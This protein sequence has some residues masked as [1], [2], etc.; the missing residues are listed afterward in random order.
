M[1]LILH[2]ID[3]KINVDISY[4]FKST[5][6]TL[7]EKDIWLWYDGKSGKWWYMKKDN[8]IDGD[9]LLDG[10]SL[11]YLIHFLLYLLIYF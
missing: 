1:K 5:F 2:R 10:I 8:F 9:K 11:I 7:E 4:K 6:C 3:K